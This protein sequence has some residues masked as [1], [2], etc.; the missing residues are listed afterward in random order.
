[1]RTQSASWVLAYRKSFNKWRNE[2]E[3]GRE[4]AEGKTR[5]FYLLTAETNIPVLAEQ[6][7]G[8]KVRDGQQS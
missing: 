6:K 2:E 5:S 8:G 3:I 7:F 4:R 1:M